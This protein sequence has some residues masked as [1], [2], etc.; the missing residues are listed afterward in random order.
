MIAD[1][2][3]FASS[4][5]VRY[6]CPNKNKTYQKS[7]SLSVETESEEGIDGHLL[8]SNY[9]ICYVNCACGQI[10]KIIIT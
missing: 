10:H 4:I 1:N 3:I 5:Y 8:D 9:P 6:Y 7:V 2:E